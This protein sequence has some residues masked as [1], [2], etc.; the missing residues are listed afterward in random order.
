MT[1]EERT[2]ERIAQNRR[3]DQAVLSGKAGLSLEGIVDQ[4]NARRQRAADGAVAGLVG[5][6]P[7]G[8][9]SGRPREPKYSWVVA[10]TTGED[11][12]RG[13]P[14]GYSVGQIDPDCY[15]QISQRLDNVIDSAA[16]LREW[17][18]RLD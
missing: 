5:V 11:S 17:L 16:E 1:P 12:Q 9:M 3:I 18:S 10:A 7:R 8:L 14:T 4:L 15:R 6:L 2:R 13:Y